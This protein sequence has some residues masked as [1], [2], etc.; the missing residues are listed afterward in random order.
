MAT[1][2]FTVPLLATPA[3]SRNGGISWSTQ[4][5]ELTA[6]SLTIEANGLTFDPSGQ[7]VLVSSDPGRPTTGS[8]WIIYEGTLLAGRIDRPFM[9]ELHLER[10]AK[11]ARL[12][13]TGVTLSVSP[14][15]W[16]SRGAWLQYGADPGRTGEAPRSMLTPATAPRLHLVWS[17][18]LGSTKG[19]GKLGDLPAG[20]VVANHTVFASGRDGLHALG[21]RS[22][23]TRWRL[24]G[25]ALRRGIGSGE[26]AAR[27]GVLYVTAADPLR[28]VVV[29]AAAGRVLWKRIG[30]TELDRST[31]VGAPVLFGRRL[32]VSS[33][34]LEL[35]SARPGQTVSIGLPARVIRWA[36]DRGVIV[37]SAAARVGIA[38]TSEG[39]VRVLDPA[40]G[41]VVWSRWLGR[42]LTAPAIRN[43]TVYIAKAGGLRGNYAIALDADSGRE[44]WRTQIGMWSNP[45]RSP[46]VGSSKVFVSWQDFEG[47]GGGLAAFDRDTGRRL[48]NAQIRGYPTAPV[49]TNGVVVVGVTKA[50]PVPGCECAE[51]GRHGRVMAFRAQTGALLWKGR[52]DGVFVARPVIAGRTVL[53]VSRGGTVYAFRTGA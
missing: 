47:L 42:W 19:G 23:G 44:R 6:S 3:G 29:D 34:D 13:I 27:N 18:A 49:L 45:S 11:G 33:R 20:L 5:L 1:V 41:S 53:A 36:R 24:W 9:G 26:L 48:W 50:V 21:M 38:T 51:I 7:D 25:G 52:A 28:V 14:R 30:S 15:S 40:D 2:L 12:D 31:A 17:R 8:S 35:Q 22:G 10:P 39:A 16:H 4:V 43:G 46:A 37:S 32:F